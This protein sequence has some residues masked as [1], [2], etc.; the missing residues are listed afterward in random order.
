MFSLY[1]DRSFVKQKSR[2]RMKNG[3]TLVE[4][5]LAMALLLTVVLI[6]SVGFLSIL[7]SSSSTME[8]QASANR[9]NSNAN[10]ILSDPASTPTPASKQQI[11]FVWKSGAFDMN[12]STLSVYSYKVDPA[13]PIE[14][15]NSD[16]R[17]VFIYTP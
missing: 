12:N 8:Y 2:A 15:P 3:F 16:N 1:S 11:T 13:L 9:A 10:K 5:I 6:I 4:T 17:H 14:N 7:R